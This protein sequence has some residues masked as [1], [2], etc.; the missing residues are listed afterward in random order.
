MSN[1][2]NALHR[3]IKT[4][5]ELDHPN[6]MALY[7]VIDNRTHVHLVMELC[8]GKNLYHLLKKRKDSAVPGLP[9]EQVKGIFK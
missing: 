3:E 9:E 6:I 1:L 7:E 5:A 2:S 8:Q 4:L